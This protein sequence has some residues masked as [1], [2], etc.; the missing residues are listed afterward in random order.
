MSE[1]PAH[2]MTSLLKMRPFAWLLLLGIAAP[3]V[4]DDYVLEPEKARHWAWQAPVRTPPPLSRDRAWSRNA[5]DDFIL[6][7]LEAAGL[8][9]ARPATREQLIRRVT[10]DLIG[11]PPT[12]AEIDAFVSDT[13]PDAWDKVV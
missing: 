5:V 8:R 1:K 9:P 10:I 12:P 11:L 3:V 13:A 2:L 7:K 6:E 4:A